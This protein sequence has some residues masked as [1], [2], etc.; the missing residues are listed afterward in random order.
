[1]AS[2]AQTPEQLQD[3]E[4]AVLEALMKEFVKF[5]VPPCIPKLNGNGFAS[6]ESIYDSKCAPGTTWGEQL[7]GAV[8]QAANR[9]RSGQTHPTPSLLGKG[10]GEAATDA[11]IRSASHH[12]TCL[13]W[14]VCLTPPHLPNMTGLPHTTVLA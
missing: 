3:E 4:R 1:M 5:G 11:V 9:V 10:G 12:P 8:L 7:I 13:L 2:K 6:Q 14:Q